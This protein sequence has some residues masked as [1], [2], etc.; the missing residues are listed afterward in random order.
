MEIRKDVSDILLADFVGATVPASL[1]GEKKAESV[2][3]ARLSLCPLGLHYTVGHTNL[4]AIVI[5]K[6]TECRLRMQF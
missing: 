5:N 4:A 6:C 1:G 3:L 2:M